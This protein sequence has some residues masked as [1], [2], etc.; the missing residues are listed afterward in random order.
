MDEIPFRE[1][2]LPNGKVVLIGKN[3]IFGDLSM[4]VLDQWKQRIKEEDNNKL[5][6]KKGYP[7]W[8]Q[9]PPEK[10]LFSNI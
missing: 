2:T 3:V 10:S 6:Q 4:K 5:T 7:E 8:E 1:V 9:L